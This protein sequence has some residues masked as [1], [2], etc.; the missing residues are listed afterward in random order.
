MRIKRFMFTLATVGVFLLAGPA[1]NAL[2]AGQHTTQASAATP[3]EC[4]SQT[5]VA[6]RATGPTWDWLHYNTDPYYPNLQSTAA[7]SRALQVKGV[8]ARQ[9]LNIPAAAWKGLT[10]ATPCKGWLRHGQKL[11]AMMS[12]GFWS[13][14]VKVEHN[15]LAKFSK[16]PV[17]AWYITYAYNGK[18]YTLVVPY[19]CGN[20]SVVV[21]P[22]PS[23]QQFYVWAWKD[24]K[25]GNEVANGQRFPV[26]AQ[27]NRN[28]QWTMI[29][30]QWTRLGPFQAGHIPK[31]FC[32]VIKAPWKAQG[33]AC[34][35][36]Y[37]EQDRLAV[38]FSNFAP[39]KGSPTAPSTPPTTVPTAQNNCQIQGGT[40]NGDTQ[41][42]TIIQVIGNNCTNVTII[43]GNGNT[44]SQ[45][46]NGSCG[47]SPPSLPPTTSNVTLA[48]STSVQSIKTV[49]AP[50]P[51]PNQSITKVGTSDL[52]TLNSP[53]F[54]G[55]GSTTQAAQD[56]LNAQLASWRA[57]NQGGVDNTATAQAQS[58]LNAALLTCPSPPPVVTTTVT[59]GTT[60][61]VYSGGLA[62][63]CAAV[64]RSDGSAVQPT[65]VSFSPAEGAM[66]SGTM[67]FVSGEGWC[68]QWR[69]PL[70]TV[71]HTVSYTA[72]AFG[73][74]SSNIMTVRPQFTGP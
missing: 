15:V 74:Q 56:S 27:G 49:T 28:K 63:L 30:G 54:T 10:Q 18:L 7:L 1:G 36:T 67:H 59:A 12:G 73:V 40:W 21:T 66:V 9:A 39:A 53:S 20:I 29:S 22:A 43:N 64:V 13:T 4:T 61:D 5:Y 17:R 47:A 41:L 70:T 46:Q 58:R 3:Q 44:V 25:V 37:T 72:W 26:Y 32:E 19:L 35:S 69:A 16:T 6:S 34:Q 48:N 50:C 60:H 57:S 33:S 24:A 2:A 23:V 65:D 51:P 42:C 11:D 62:D 8:Q 52:I 45:T 55:T 31:Q 38:K 71:I 68:Q 14:K